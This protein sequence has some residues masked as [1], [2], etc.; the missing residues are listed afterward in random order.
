MAATFASAQPQ[1]APPVQ[2]DGPVVVGIPREKWSGV[3]LKNYTAAF[4]YRYQWQKDKLE[5]TG[6]E[7]Q[8]V[9][10]TRNRYLLD[11]TG[12]LIIGHRNLIDITGSL[13]LGLEDIKIDD[14]ALVNSSSDEQDTIAF[15][16][17]NALLFGSSALP[18]NVYAIRSETQTERTFA[19][20]V[21]ETLQEEGF[22]TNYLTETTSTILQYFHRDQTITD[23]L[24]T[25][26][27]NTVQDELSL[28]SGIKLTPDSRVDIWYTFDH[29]DENQEGQQSDSY[30]R[31][32][33]NLVHLQGFG[34][35][36]NPN[37]LRS[38]LRYYGQTGL[39]DQ[40][41]LRWDEVLSLRPSDRFDTRFATLFEQVEVQGKT[42]Q[43]VRGD[44]TARYK[45]FDSLVS[46][47]T[48][49]AQQFSTDTNF[50]SDEIF[51]TGQLDYTKSVPLGTLQIGL[52]QS[53][54]D[55][56]NSE[57]GSTIDILNQPF[58]YNDG[59]PIIIARRNIIPSSIVITAPGGFP[60]YI[61]GSDYTVTA[62]PDRVEI[63][64]V[65]G[66]A[67]VN[68]QI[69]SVSYDL[70]PEPANEIL[71]LGGTLS[72]RYTIKEGTFDGLALY[73]LYRYVQNDLQQGDPAVIL[74][75]NLDEWVGGVQ[76]IRGGLDTLAEYILHNSDF[77][78]YTRIRGQVLY[79]L[80][81]A[82]QS[83]ITFE[84]THE[85][86]DFD[87]PSNHVDYD[88]VAFR[89]GWRL[90]DSLDVNTVLQYRQENSTLNGDST[91]I[92]ETIGFAW[93][94]GLTSAY[95]RFR[96]ASLDGTDSNQEDQFF[97]FGI[98]RAF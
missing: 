6:V 66:G 7:T 97:E 90:S 36:G 39:Q 25:I 1:G 58:T 41:R 93:H 53:V 44:A 47:V 42:S 21:K 5:Q 67:W 81:V 55:Q 19:S 46:T 12:E 82:P 91:G 11:T 75:D 16:N 78:P 84:Y 65:T 85:T 70:G 77:D 23:D 95:A 94:K 18:T 34:G 35:E 30:D 50:T 60:T 74:L 73:G 17:I 10:E 3:Q 2:D 80:N 79:S 49:G 83:L 27:S 71:T 69:V 26:N 45:L 92:E 88:R 54:V 43:L 52:G 63:R 61:E 14:S 98:R 20:T 37:D 72:V 51:F 33:L 62:Y 4:E 57:Q 87:N 96:N 29:I 56:K 32:D 15:Y 40:A 59:F 64:G 9:T 86:I 24:G 89:T 8:E 28:Q 31:N 38:S 68:G 76:Y 13:Q 22:N 48:G